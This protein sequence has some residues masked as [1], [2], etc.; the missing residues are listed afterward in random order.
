MFRII[1]N[2]QVRGVRPAYND[3]SIELQHKL[4]RDGDYVRVQEFVTGGAIPKQIED[5]DDDE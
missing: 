5:E 2:G 1:V 4:S 3:T